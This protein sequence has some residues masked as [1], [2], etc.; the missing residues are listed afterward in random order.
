MIYTYFVL[1]IFFALAV[2]LSG[3][4]SLKWYKN[5]NR[6]TQTKVEN[7]YCWNLNIYRSNCRNSQC[8][9]KNFQSLNNDCKTR[10]HFHNI[11]KY[12]N[13][14]YLLQFFFL[15]TIEDSGWNKSPVFFKFK[16]HKK[17]FKFH[18]FPFVLLYGPR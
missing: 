7:N 14:T 8:L 2:L 13:N 12:N 16:I 3:V 11:I 6:V 17:N 1:F 18:V 4:Y 10:G 9:K 5:K 15:F